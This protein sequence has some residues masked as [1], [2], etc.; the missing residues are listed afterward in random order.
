[1]RQTSISF[2]SKGLSLEGV[3]AVPDTG[4]SFPGVVLCHG[5]TIFGG[6]MDSPLFMEITKELTTRGY[7]CLRFNFRGVG[8]SE[9]KFSNGETEHHDVIAA[10]KVISVWPGV[11]R[12]RLALIGHSFGASTILLA[13]KAMRLA[14][15]AVL[16]S[17]TISSIRR[18]K[19][20]KEKRPML[21]IAGSEDRIVPVDRLQEEIQAAHS[22][23]QLEIV[24]GADHIYGNKEIDVS[25][26][27]ANYLNEVI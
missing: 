19:L 12:S 10:L 26:E 15:A 16:L 1:M 25:A 2:Q 20:S 6:G 11:N 8:N 5:H 22:A 27:I 23:Q 17:P 13:L 14:S 4:S 24:V 18:A 9:G 3:V 21:F 7:A